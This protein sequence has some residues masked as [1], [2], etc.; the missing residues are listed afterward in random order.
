MGRIIGDGFDRVLLYLDEGHGDSAVDDLSAV[1][2]RGMAAGTRHPGITETHGERA[3]LDAALSDLQ[4]GDL[5]VLGVDAIEEALAFVK[6]RL[7]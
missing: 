7:G 2:R 3:A 1:L 4:S 6:S 5:L